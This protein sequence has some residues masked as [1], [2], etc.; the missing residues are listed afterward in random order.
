MGFTA[1][2]KIGNAVARNRAKRRLRALFYQYSPHLKEGIYIF[3]SKLATVS[4]S[5]AKLDADFSKMLKISKTVLPKDDP[6]ITA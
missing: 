4:D 3:V 2:K 1:T 6:K 5:H